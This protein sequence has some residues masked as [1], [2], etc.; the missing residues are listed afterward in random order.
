MIFF[1][2]GWPPW[3]LFQF[4]IKMAISRCADEHE[5]TGGLLSD[6]RLCEA[7]L[8]DPND[9]LA[10]LARRGQ[11]PAAIELCAALEAHAAEDPFR[12]DEICAANVVLASMNEIANAVSESDP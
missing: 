1:E 3:D 5:T 9:S 10:T 8:R 11:T 4:R 6:L 12:Y 7:F 2:D